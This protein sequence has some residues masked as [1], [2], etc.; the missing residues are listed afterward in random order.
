M[1]LNQNRYH[2][3]QCSKCGKGTIHFWTLPWNKFGHQDSSLRPHV[4][5]STCVSELVEGDYSKIVRKVKREAKKE[6]HY[7][8]RRY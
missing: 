2:Y 4:Y 5:C 7:A 6:M 1:S 8:D 3:N